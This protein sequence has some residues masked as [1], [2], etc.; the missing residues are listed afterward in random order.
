MAVEKVIFVFARKEE[1]WLAGFCHF[2][3]DKDDCY[4]FSSELFLLFLW[5][6]LR[7]VVVSGHHNKEGRY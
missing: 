7:R 1:I 2:D 4:F 5:A 6:V 3:N